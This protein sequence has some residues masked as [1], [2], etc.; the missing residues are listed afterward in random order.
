ML[1]L[2]RDKMAST[3]KGVRRSPAVRNSL[4]CLYACQHSVG[5]DRGEELDHGI[6]SFPAG[7]CHAKL[8]AR[9]LQAPLLMCSVE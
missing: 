4:T 6:T 7:I 1:L 2:L 3:V 9:E 8:F 5:L